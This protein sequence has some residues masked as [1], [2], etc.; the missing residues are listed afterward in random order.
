LFSRLSDISAQYSREMI[1]LA[2]QADEVTLTSVISAA[3]RADDLLSF[4]ESVHGCVVKLGYKDT[5]SCS[6]RIL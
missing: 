1:R 6:W 3:S 5:A 2:V 4:G